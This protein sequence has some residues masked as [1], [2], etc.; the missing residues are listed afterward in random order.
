MFMDSCFDKCKCLLILNWYIYYKWCMVQVRSIGLAMHEVVCEQSVA[1]DVM[2]GR[3]P[4][5][6]LPMR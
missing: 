1:G 2:S 4:F 6:I 3:L 5:F